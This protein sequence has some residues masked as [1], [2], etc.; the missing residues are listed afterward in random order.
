MPR[1]SIIFFAILPKTVALRMRMHNVL[2]GL[3]S[4]VQRMAGGQ[5]MPV[6]AGVGSAPTGQSAVEAELGKL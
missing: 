4:Q 1:L 6:G 3:S 5:G 2:L